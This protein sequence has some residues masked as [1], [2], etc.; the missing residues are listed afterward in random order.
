MKLNDFVSHQAVNGL[1]PSAYLGAGAYLS[2][3]LLLTEGAS[4]GNVESRHN[5]WLNGLLGRS[6]QPSESLLTRF[7][8]AHI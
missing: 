8:L 1:G 6:E 5:S 4:I 2:S 7:R 3:K